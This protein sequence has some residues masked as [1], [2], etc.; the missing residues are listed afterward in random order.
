MSFSIPKIG[1]KNHIIALA[2]LTLLSGIIVILQFKNLNSRIH[3]LERSV[4][5]LS[6][7]W[8][9]TQLKQQNL[10]CEKP[11]VEA[12]TQSSNNIQQLQNEYKEYQY[13]QDPSGVEESN[14]LMVSNGED[15][16]EVE[17]H[18]NENENENVNDDE[19]TVENTMNPNLEGVNLEAAKAA[20]LR[21]ENMEETE[22]T[23]EDNM[24]ENNEESDGEG[25]DDEND[26]EENI[27]GFTVSQ[28]K[29]LIREKGG[30]IPRK[31]VKADLVQLYQSL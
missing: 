25:E 18:G 21:Q 12:P 16:T 7:E 2:L 30:T 17:E 29:D 13:G 19:E 28:L 5:S 6:T 26:M 23:M 9:N 10:T 22:Q 1:L 14:S 11:V 4:N 8:T 27:N 31:V 15:T 20:I 3:R 24:E